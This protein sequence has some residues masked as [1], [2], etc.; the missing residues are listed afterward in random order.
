MT[1]GTIGF[2][3]ETAPDERRCLLTA[4]TATALLD[5]GYQVVAEPGIGDGIFQTDEELT[6]LGV[7]FAA[8]EQVWAAP[9]VLRYKSPHPDDLARLTPGQAVAALFHAEGDPQMLRALRSSRVTAYSYEFLRDGEHHP[10]GVPGAE[11][12]GAQAV[13]HGAFAVQAGYGG[14]GVLVPAVAGAPRARVV[15]IGTGNLGGAAARTAAA[16]GAQVTVLAR[17]EQSA[18]RYA[19]GAPQAVAV[20]VN[21]PETLCAALASADLVIGAILISTFDTP[22]MITERHLRLMRPG[23]VIVDATCG[24]G[25][26]YLP[27]AGPV[28]KPGD[29]PLLAHGILHVK[30][31][32]WPQLTPVTTSA[33]Y[34]ATAAPYLRRLADVVLRGATDE[35]IDTAC[36]ARDG[37]LIHPVCRQHEAHYTSVTGA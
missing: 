4:H 8:S 14:R 6:A 22:A 16:F 5:A 9:L 31:D 1:A 7:R 27:T 15:V 2:P 19:A 36:I 21:T 12:A 10:L 18:Q 37:D 34:T 32:V 20:Q 35:A 25:D 26:G 11:I 13:L 23:A 17:T 28:Q 33:A 30:V 29:P 3:R 24:Y